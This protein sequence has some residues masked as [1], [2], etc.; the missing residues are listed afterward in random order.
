M[1]LIKNLLRRARLVGPVDTD[2]VNGLLSMLPSGSETHSG[3][4]VTVDS[5]LH[6]TTVLACVRVISETLASLPAHVYERAGNQRRLAVEYPAYRLIHRQPN[7]EITSFEFREWMQNNVLIYGNGYAVIERDRFGDPVALWPQIA[8]RVLAYRSPGTKELWYRVHN[9]GQS[10]EVPAVNML[11]IRGFAVGGLVGRS[12]VELGSNAIGLDAVQQRYAGRVFASGGSQRTAL[13]YPGKELSDNAKTNIRKSWRA[14][15]GSAEHVHDAAVLEEGM[16]VKV[17]GVNPGE[18]QLI[19]GRTYQVTELARLFRVPLHMVAE[20]SRSTFS[21]IE[22]QGLE[23]VKYTVLPW[24]ERWEQRLDMSLLSGDD[25]NHYCKLSVEG[26]LRGDSKARAEFYRAMFGIG[27]LSANDIRALEDLDTIGPQGDHYLVPLNMAP[28]SA[29]EQ[30]YAAPEAEPEPGVAAA[31]DR[32]DVS[33]H[34]HVIERLRERHMPLLEA[35]AGRIVRAEVQHARAEVKRGTEP[36]TMADAVHT[37]K[38]RDL[39]WAQLAPVFQV[40]AEVISEAVEADG[41]YARDLLEA[42]ALWDLVKMYLRES[43]SQYEASN[44]VGATLDV[45]V[46]DRPAQV[47]AMIWDYVLRMVSGGQKE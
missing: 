9:A 2:G 40:V 31:A 38:L 42:D 11:H 45:W 28:A 10:I 32:G 16:T 44:D 29:I 21:N 41:Q 3:E 19:E 22:H 23:F 7:P 13:E 18:A 47:A 1:G 37:E 46:R 4:Q 35:A 30:I 14:I 27:A 8:S 39:M 34:S 33:A 26:L 24:I 17:I 6:G 12:L 36:A 25:L 5:A 20:L 43:R 15:Y